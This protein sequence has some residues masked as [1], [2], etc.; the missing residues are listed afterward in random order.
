MTKSPCKD[1]KDRTIHCHDRCND[2][3]EYRV[4][5]DKTKANRHQ[6]SMNLGYSIEACRRMGVGRRL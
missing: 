1:C 2:Y 4:K 6:S 3:Q 5:M